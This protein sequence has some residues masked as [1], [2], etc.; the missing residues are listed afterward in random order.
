MIFFITEFIVSN[1][2]TATKNNNAIQQWI[3]QGNVD[4]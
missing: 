1:V 2:K 4:I 3:H